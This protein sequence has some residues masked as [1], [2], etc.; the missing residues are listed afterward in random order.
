MHNAAI[1]GVGNP[2]RA[3]DGVGIILL[4]KLKQRQQNLP[5]H[6]DFIDGGTGGMRLLHLFETYTFVL[7]IDAV[8]FCQKPGY[9]QLINLHEF[10]KT[11][12]FPRSFSTHEFDLHQLFTLAASLQQLP[13][14]CYLYGIQPK[15]ISFGTAM[16]DE[17]QRRLQSYV[18][19]IRKQVSQLLAV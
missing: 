15:D 10:D 12:S 2:L 3:D 17:I 1:I 13:D 7:L 19:E 4:N 8:D 14:H 9:A 18:Q 16:T 5:S 6:L 11:S